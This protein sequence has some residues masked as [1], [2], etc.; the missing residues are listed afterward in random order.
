MKDLGPLK[1]FMGI[2]VLRSKKGMFLTQRKYTLD[3]LK[4]T[5]MTACNPINTPM[6]KNMKLCIF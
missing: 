2:E 6:A 5:G 4:E 1:Y 3:L